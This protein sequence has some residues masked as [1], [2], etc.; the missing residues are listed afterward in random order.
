MAVTGIAA[1]AVEQLL[2]AACARNSPAELF[3]ESKDGM[4]VTAR[5]RLLELTA[6][7]LL[8]DEP[9]CVDGDAAIPTGEPITLHVALGGKRYQ[10][11]S[12][13]IATER[14][15]HL[16]ARQCIPGIALQRPV[17]LTPSQRRSHLR[18]SMVGYD[19]ISVNLVQACDPSIAACPIDATLVHGWMVDLSVGGMSVLID[20]RVLPKASRGDRFF[21][22]Y[23][24]PDIED[25]F[26]IHTTVRHAR[27]VASSES[28][29]LALRFQPWDGQRLTHD[30]RRLSRFVTDHERRMLRQR[31]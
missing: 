20:R 5:V 8:A 24:L 13:I 27:D 22:S 14:S 9:I 4:V 15:I 23:R 18:V 25:E 29:R 17:V 31:K 6:D 7:E 3:Y 19:P 30:Q 26:L 2:G 10:F 11:S 1:D 12:A 21:V 16:N 28:I